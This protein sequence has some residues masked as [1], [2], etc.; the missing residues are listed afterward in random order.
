MNSDVVLTA[1]EFAELVLM[2]RDE[3]S[4]V[5]ARAQK[6]I[7]WRKHTLDVRWETRN[8]GPQ[9]VVRVATLPGQLILKFEKNRS[10]AE[11]RCDA[12]QAADG[13]PIQEPSA[14]SHTQTRAVACPPDSTKQDLSPEEIMSRFGEAPKHKQDIAL[15]KCDALRSVNDLVLVGGWK[16]DDA[17]K[18]VADESKISAATIY[19]WF[20]AVRGFD[21]Q[22]W[23]G[24]LVVDR[25]GGNVPK[26]EV[27]SEFLEVIWTQYKQ[28]TQ[29]SFDTCLWTAKRV[30]P[31]MKP[32]VKIPA[33]SDK[34]IQRRFFE[35]Y[36]DGTRVLYREGSKAWRAKCHTSQT[37]DRSGLNAL[38]LIN[39]DGHELDYLVRFNDGTE[40]RVMATFWMDLSSN[41]LFEPYLAP[42]ENTDTIHR[43]FMLLCEKY[44]I[45]KGVYID[46]GMGYAGK[47]L[48]GGDKSRHRFKKIQD[49]ATGVFRLMGVKTTWALP[50]RGQSKPI[51]RQFR[52]LEGHLKLAGVDVEA[53][54]LGRV[55]TTRACLS[56]ARSE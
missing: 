5:F 8:G 18:L 52:T 3:A 54:F 19:N 49:E 47:A 30:A 39:G 41:Y 45:P 9:R 48:S 11:A 10:R 14:A 32:P 38:E 1:S 46:N 20:T 6:G 44:G 4:K 40:G 21:E 29:S 15:N 13:F 33:C 24:V 12:S 27:A 25:R 28:K 2:R 23:P 37:R 31:M 53:A 26:M 16:K 35:R 36:P 22:L 50:R 51:E 56:P 43:S 7:V 55:N 42:S 17:V 34:T